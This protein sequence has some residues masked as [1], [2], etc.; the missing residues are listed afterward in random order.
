MK[1]V[2]GRKMVRILE[3]LGWQVDRWHG[4][5]AIMEKGE[6]IVVVPCHSNEALPRGTQRVILRDAG[7][8]L[9]EFAKLA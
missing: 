3:G 1:P 5:H 4:S 7:V 9:K 6:H 8:D 2:S